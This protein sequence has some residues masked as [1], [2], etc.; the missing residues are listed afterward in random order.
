MEKHEERYM[1]LA[2]FVVIIGTFMSILDSSIVNVAIPKMMAIFGAGTDEIEWVLTG[3]MLTMGIIIPL[4]GFLSDRFG[5]KTMYIF[6]LS[7][8]TVG[9]ALCGIANSTNTMVAARV[10]QAIGGGMIM[11]VGMSMIYQIVPIE[12]RGLAL[13][14]WGISAMAA[15][16]IG[17]TLSGY[18][19]EYLNW[20]LIFTINIPVGIIGVTLASIILRDS[21]KVTGKKFDIWGAVTIAIGLFTLLLAL[22]KVSSKGWTSGYTIGMFA[23]S[24]IS[25]LLFVYIEL[26]HDEPLL[27]LGVLK[28]FPYSLSL[29]INTITTIGLFGAVFLIPL[30]MENLRGYSAMQTGIL[31]L[32]QAIVTGFMMPISGKLFDKYGAKWLTIIGLAIMTFCTYLLSKITLDTP[33]N[34]LMLILAFRGLGMGICM[35]PIQTAGMNSVP[36]QLVARASALNNTVRQVAGSLGIS[37]LTTIL[38]HRQVFHTVKYSEM[39]NTSS[40]AFAQ[41]QGLAQGLAV[42]GGL[43]IAAAKSAIMMQIYGSLIKQATMTA[44]NDTFLV[45]SLICLAGIPLAMLIR[46]KAKTNYGKEDQK[47]IEEEIAIGLFE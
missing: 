33:Y 10:I 1:W 22:D 40:P 47:E 13:G 20:R 35:M 41:A 38:Q 37:V 23:I 28:I 12:K 24:L 46:K 43:T 19:V 27:D 8:F 32:P 14:V 4:T 5:S 17:P 7:V 3:Y 44:M 18:I 45:A 34:T 39:V 11:P 30:F 36:P 26:T 21:K 9:S 29:I 6:A 31:M 16:A 42:K 2:L 15:P 25:L